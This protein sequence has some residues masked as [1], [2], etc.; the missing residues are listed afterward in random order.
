MFGQS[1]P[2]ARASDRDHGGGHAHAFAALAMLLAAC[3]IALLPGEAESKDGPLAVHAAAQQ[4]GGAHSAALGSSADDGGGV[5]PDTPRPPVPGVE[6]MDAVSG[7]VF[8]IREAHQML[9][10]SS[11]TLDQGVDL[12]FGLGF[13]RSFC[14]SKATLV[15]VEDAVVTHIGLNGFGSKSPV[16]KLTRG[17]YRNR[18]VYYGHSQPTM[19]KV[20]QRVKRGQAISRIGCGIVGHSSA[21][22]LE[23][24]IY[25]KGQT[26]CCPSW[27]ETS[28]T[29]YSI[30]KR[31]WPTAV[32]RAKAASR[33]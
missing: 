20:G 23:I 31:M 25:R 24:G 8:P 6:P 4:A 11:W 29:M 13:S 21:P 9:G 7:W 15:A 16:I 27:G 30:L 14:G 5:D 33:R 2:K 18:Q 28:G 32:K 3:V 19:V 22:H 26:Y 1:S 17:P 10:I 12:G